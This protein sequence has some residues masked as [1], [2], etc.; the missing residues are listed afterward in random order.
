V[1]KCG[2]YL[3]KQLNGTALKQCSV[4]IFTLDGSMKMPTDNKD[5]Y[6][7]KQKRKAA[8]IED[9]YESKG[10]SK[11][12]AEARAWA[13]VNKQSGGGEKKGGSGT[14]KPAGAKAN[15]RKDSAKRAAAAREDDP[16]NGRRA[17]ADRTKADLL[18]RARELDISGRSTMSKPQLVEAIGKAQ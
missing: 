1:N 9:S 18:K 15:D 12:E 11:D 13:T 6:T 7:D 10:V 17:L 8:K 14:K 4:H 5:K 2:E 16:Q 3:P